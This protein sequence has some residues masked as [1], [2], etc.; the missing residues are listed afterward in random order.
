[1]WRPS[2]VSSWLA[3]SV[4]DGN[5]DLSIQIDLIISGADDMEFS[6][7]ITTALAVTALIG[8][9]QSDHEPF[10]SDE[11]AWSHSSL[12]PMSSSYEE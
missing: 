8:W 10:I 12:N 7:I 1:M 4:S 3:S 5:I 11:E 6:D 2:C 9:L